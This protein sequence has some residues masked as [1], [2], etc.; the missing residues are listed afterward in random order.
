MKDLNKLLEQAKIAFKRAEDNLSAC[1]S[2]AMKLT[3]TTKPE[4]AWFMLASMKDTLYWQSM[5]SITLPVTFNVN[6]DMSA[7]MAKEA[8]CS[9]FNERC[10]LCEEVERSR[11]EVSRIEQLIKFLEV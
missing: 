7:K 1:E 8:L 9:W 10:Q 6:F 2:E 5:Y 4:A 11:R 3:N